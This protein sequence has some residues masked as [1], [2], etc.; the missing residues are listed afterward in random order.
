MRA[1]VAAIASALSIKDSELTDVGDL[2]PILLVETEYGRDQLRAEH[3]W[4]DTLAE[5]LE[6]G[7]IPWGLPPATAEL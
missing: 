7:E 5:R 1:R 2:P 3:D 4:F 6:S